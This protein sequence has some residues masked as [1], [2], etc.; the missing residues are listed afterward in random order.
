M[1][2]GLVQILFSH[3]WA[4]ATD[5]PNTAIKRQFTQ[6]STEQSNQRCLQFLEF[7]L[8]SS[9]FHLALSEPEH[10]PPNL[11]CTAFS[12]LTFLPSAGAIQNGYICGMERKSYP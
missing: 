5:F 12:C 7:E 1:P 8:T 9:Q 2:P 10:F 6:A 11:C 3:G 4:I